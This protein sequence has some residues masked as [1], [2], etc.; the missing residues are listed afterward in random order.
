MLFSI[1]EKPSKSTQALN[2]A[3]SSAD[4]QISVK[5]KL[6]SR[7]PSNVNVVTAVDKK[8]KVVDEFAI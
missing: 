5:K 6:F 1:K 8:R 7:K 2:Q 4:T 3:M